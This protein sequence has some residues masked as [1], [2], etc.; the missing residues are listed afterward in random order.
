MLPIMPFSIPTCTCSQLK[1]ILSPGR[2]IKKT[3]NKTHTKNIYGNLGT[4]KRFD[5]I[6]RAKPLSLSKIEIHL[7]FTYLIIGLIPL[8]KK[9]TLWNPTIG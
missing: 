6:E 5:A 2:S 1:A 3:T 9:L 4:N 8:P 7:Y